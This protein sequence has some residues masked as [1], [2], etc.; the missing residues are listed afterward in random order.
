M[1]DTNILLVISVLW[2]FSIFVVFFFIKQ[3]YEKD[4]KELSL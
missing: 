4:T 2:V 1:F 3:K